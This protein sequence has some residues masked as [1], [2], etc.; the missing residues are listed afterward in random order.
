MVVSAF[1]LS[2]LLLASLNL[3]AQTRKPASAVPAMSADCSWSDAAPFPGKVVGNTVA[4]AGGNLYSFGGSIDTLISK[5][6]FKFDGITWTPIASYPLA[7]NGAAAVTDGTNIYIVGGAAQST[8]ERSPTAITYAARFLHQPANGH[9]VVYLDGKL[10]KFGGRDIDALEIYDI[11]SDAWRT[12]APYPQ[13]TDL[14]GGFAQGPFV[15]GAGGLVRNLNFV[16]QP[17]RKTYRYD[18]GNDR[19]DD[20]AIADLP[21]TRHGAAAPSTRASASWRADFWEATSLR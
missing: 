3:E 5:R 18:P 21:V 11:G 13:R 6:A 15:Y 16:L 17:T 9:A 12:A 19:W 8:R 2:G 7:I 1:G 14:L 4:S 10:Y 20:E